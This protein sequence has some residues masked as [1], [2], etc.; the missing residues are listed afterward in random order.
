[1]RQ[2]TETMSMCAYPAWD[3]A[4]PPTTPASLAA[5][6]AHVR[7]IAAI[8]AFYRLDATEAEEEGYGEFLAPCTVNP[9][10]VRF[11][12]AFAVCRAHGLVHDR[13]LGLLRLSTLTRDGH[14]WADR[15][16]YSPECYPS[17]ATTGVVR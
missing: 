4:C 9:G 8:Q 12:V 16:D 1:M 17:P 7:T 3:N 11:A 13:W 14:E 2:T 6:A 15:H 5:A 10:T